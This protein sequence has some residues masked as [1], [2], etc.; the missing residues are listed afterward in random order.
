MPWNEV[1]RIGSIS[2]NVM[3]SLWIDYNLYATCNWG[4][5]G[6]RKILYYGQL[7]LNL[8]VLLQNLPLQRMGISASEMGPEM[9]ITRLKYDQHGILSV[10]VRSQAA[11][12]RT[13]KKW[14]SE[15]EQ[16]CSG[17]Q[18]LIQRGA[19][20][21][22][23]LTTWTRRHFR[24]TDWNNLARYGGVICTTIW[25]V[26]HLISRTRVFDQIWDTDMSNWKV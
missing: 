17:F 9:T 19:S 3:C 26:T 24:R 11:C 15:K 13:P 21:L 7:H 5:R 18:I 22:S 8:R 2:V 16:I 20:S 6:F 25:N 10:S 23:Q 14:K 12:F 4:R 1:R